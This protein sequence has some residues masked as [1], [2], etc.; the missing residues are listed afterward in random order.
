METTTLNGFDLEYEVMG[1]GE[2]VLLIGTGPFADSFLPL[3]SEEAL[4]GR[5]RLIRYRQRGQAGG[6]RSWAPVSFAEHAGDAA[7][8]LG[9]LGVGRAHVAGHST[10]G[11]IALELAAGHPT[12]VHTLALLEPPL[13]GVPS[14]G[15]FFEKIGPS[16]AAY[17]AGAREAAMA[18]FLSVV[19]SLEWATCRALVEQR[20][21][22]SVTQAIEHADGFF[23]SYVPAIAEWRF[24]LER[25]AAISQPVLSVLGGETEQLF[26]EGHDLLHAWFP[27]LEDCPVEGVAHLLHLQDPGPVARG[28]AAFFARHPITAD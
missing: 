18:G 11:V 2:P 10:G 20:V 19:S 12:L 27:Q 5:Y 14:A 6:A 7:A 9:H 24:G 15:S 4:A 21:P 28:M 23:G 25:A 13:A 22:G 16:L 3:M 1:S 8:L 26:V 17:S